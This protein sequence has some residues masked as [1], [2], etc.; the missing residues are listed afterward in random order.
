MTRM[1]DIPGGTQVIVCV[2]VM[3]DPSLMRLIY[4]PE[5]GNFNFLC[6]RDHD[7]EKGSDA[8]WIHASHVLELFP[9][10]PPE[11]CCPLGH[12]AYFDDEFEQ[13]VVDTLLETDDM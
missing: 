6:L 11:L 10:V 8:T 13:W 9:H 2:H 1:K 12:V 4:H 3:D 5:P 7:M